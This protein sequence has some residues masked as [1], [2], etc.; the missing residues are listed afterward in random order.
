MAS[1]PIVLV[2]EFPQIPSISDDINF[3]LKKFGNKFIFTGGEVSD[4]K[5]YF[6]SLSSEKQEVFVKKS[7]QKLIEHIED[8]YPHTLID[9]DDSGE[10]KWWKLSLGPEEETLKIDMISIEDKDQSFEFDKETKIG[11]FQRIFDSHKSLDSFQ[12]RV[13]SNNN[14]IQNWYTL[15]KSGEDY[16]FE[17]GLF[18][19]EYYEGNEEDQRL[20]FTFYEEELENHVK[21]LDD[22]HTIKLEENSNYYFILEAGFLRMIIEE[23]NVV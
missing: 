21:N 7:I 13:Y 5:K 12:H 18:D 22:R 6:Q 10:E 17:V 1:K 9:N 4:I 3:K 15:K 23:E 8:E 19:F 16:A 11:D 2:F 20:D 14:P